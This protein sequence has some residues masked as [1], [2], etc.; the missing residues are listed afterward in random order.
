MSQRSAAEGAEGSRGVLR[1]GLCPKDSSADWKVSHSGFSA[2]KSKTSRAGSCWTEGNLP[3]AHG[4]WLEALPS[5]SSPKVFKAAALA[6]ASASSNGEVTREFA[7]TQA[8][9]AA[10]C[11]G[12]KSRV[13][14]EGVV[15]KEMIS[16]VLENLPVFRF[17][18]HSRG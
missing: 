10:L 11:A 2:R 3:K 9:K 15:F 1:S 12:L 7:C 18:A 4:I 6:S 8:S 17:P 13:R 14:P 16:R 5:F